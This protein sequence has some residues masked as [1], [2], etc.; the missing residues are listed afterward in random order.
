MIEN[1][2]A[3]SKALMQPTCV[4]PRFVPSAS[5]RVAPNK[6]LADANKSGSRRDQLRDAAPG[7][8]SGAPRP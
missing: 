3:T 2:H 5:K 6:T 7:A 8:L 1:R 4:T